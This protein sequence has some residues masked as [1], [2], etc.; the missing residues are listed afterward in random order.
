MWFPELELEE[1][2]SKH[3]QIYDK[4]INVSKMFAF[5]KILVR[6]STE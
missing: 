6:S 5:M 4:T 2:N 1:K 3:L